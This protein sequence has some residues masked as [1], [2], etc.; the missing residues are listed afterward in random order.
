MPWLDKLAAK[1]PGIQPVIMK[2]NEPVHPPYAYPQNSERYEVGIRVE[3]AP[4]PVPDTAF[5]AIGRDSAHSKA[6]QWRY[7]SL[8]FSEWLGVMGHPF[9]TGMPAVPGSMVISMPRGRHIPVRER[10]NIGSPGSVSLGELT[11]LDGVQSWAPSL[12]KIT[13]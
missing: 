11:L 2:R 5:Y 9:L 4:R 12:A 3:E 10:T 13:L 1:L 8:A 7:T 6:Y